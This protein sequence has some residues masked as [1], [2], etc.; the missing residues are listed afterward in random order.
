MGN[1]SYN[2]FTY[3][4]TNVFKIEF[5]HILSY[6]YLYFPL[7][8]TCLGWCTTGSQLQM[9]L[10]WWLIHF[11]KDANDNSH[12]KQDWLTDWTH[13][14]AVKIA[15]EL[16]AMALMGLVWAL[17]SP[18]WL[19][20]SMFHSLRKPPRHPLNRMLLAGMNFRAHT[21]S[22]WAEFMDFKYKITTWSLKS[23]FASN[24]CT[25]TSKIFRENLILA[26]LAKFLMSLK[27]CM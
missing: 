1:S 7:T 14:E 13:L 18:S 17:I 12:D 21:Q 4:S 27:M 23:M 24:Y 22:L 2:W 16:A 3:T 5:Y 9:I 10:L 20:F 26:L 6:A 25:C 19:Q 8:N 11:N 15:E